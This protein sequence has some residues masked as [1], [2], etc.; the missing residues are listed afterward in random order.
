MAV[1]VTAAV[2]VGYMGVAVT[3]VLD[4]RPAPG[5]LGEALALLLILFVIQ[6][7]HSFPELTPNRWIP[8]RWSLVAQIVLTYG[9]FLIFRKA[10][11]GIPGFLAGSVLL[12]A[13]IL[14][15]WVF[16]S[17]ILASTDVVLFEVGLGWSDVAYTTVA[18]A[19]T[20]LVVFG[21]SRLTGMVREVH[22]SRAELARLAVDQE[23]LRFARD[24]HDL[25]GYS[26]STITLKCELAYRL[27]P[28]QNDLAQQE[29]SEVLQTSRQ[30]L[31]DVRAVARGYRDMSL[32]AEVQSAE[33]M[34]AAVGIRTTTRL[35]TGDLSTPVDTLLA[36]VLREG[37][38]N[39]LR[40]S[41][42]QNC[43]IDATTHGRGVRFVLANDGVNK[44]SSTLRA[45]GADG[46]SGLGNLRVRVEK[47]GGTL[48]AGAPDCNAFRLAVDIPM[49]PQRGSGR[50]GPGLVSGGHG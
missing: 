32:A 31:A 26:L 1:V 45:D 20:G 15:A 7:G 16:Y 2:L 49:A 47:L 22:R 39:M 37:L 27:V 18:T 5:R 50:G 3:Y 6:L 30:A 10:W 24:L 28:Q 23:R 36:T 13:P 4:S 17:V 19:L 48:D 38:T 29:I 11:L 14:L 34:L 40:H 46:G 33:S 25:L 21:L 41:R 44:S 43:R 35:E 12:L 9:P 42:A 8:V